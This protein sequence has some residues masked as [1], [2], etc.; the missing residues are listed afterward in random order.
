VSEL[1]NSDACPRPTTQAEQP[2]ESNSPRSR[3]KRLQRQLAEF[4]EDE[5]GLGRIV[6]LYHRSSASY[7]IC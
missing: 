6:A 1:V 4:S 2:V 3:H 5:V 7:R